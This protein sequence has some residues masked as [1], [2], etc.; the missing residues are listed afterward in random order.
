MSASH[1]A[2][3]ILAHPDSMLAEALRLARQ[4]YPVLRVKP[5]KSPATDHGF[6]DAT[7]NPAQITAWWSRNPNYM[8]GVRTGEAS[9]LAVLD[10]DIKTDPATGEVKIDGSKALQE[11]M[12]R[13]G[14]TLPDTVSVQT[15]S[16]GR[17]LYFQH[18]DGFKSN[19]HN[20]VGI[21]YRCE[22]GYIVFPPSRRADGKSYRF[23]NPPGLFEIAKA[24]EWL[25]E[26]F[27]NDE[28]PGLIEKWQPKDNG[29]VTNVAGTGKELPE[30]Y[31]H[32][33]ANDG[34]SRREDVERALEGYWNPDAYDDWYQ[35]AMALHGFPNGLEIWLA[36]ASRSGK[37]NR[38]ENIRKWEQTVPERGKTVASILSRVDRATLSDWGREHASREHEARQ[39]TER[40]SATVE[41][42]KPEGGAP[43]DFWNPW[44]EPAGPPFPLE[45]L[46]DPVADYVR[47]RYAETGA[48]ASAIAMAC[49]AVLSAAIT[50]ETRLKLNKGSWRSSAR[51]WGLLAGNVSA[52]KSLVMDGA[53]HP[54]AECQ[55][56]NAVHAR[57]LE[58]EQEAE[59]GK[60]VRVHYDRYSVNDVTPE[61]LCVAL[62]NQDRGI[63]LHADEVTAWIGSLDRY[64]NE[65]GRKFY[66][67]AYNGEPYEALRVTR[68]SPPV[69][70]LSIS[71]LGG[72]Q[73]TLLPSLQ[74]LTSDGLLQRF[75]PVVMAP[76]KPPSDD[77]DPEATVR[78][79][80]LVSA[81]VQL[82]K[83]TLHLAHGAYP[84]RDAVREL[85]D[86]VGKSDGEGEGWQGFTG[87]LTGIWGTLALIL[88]IACHG[89]QWGQA[90]PDEV[91]VETATLA[92]RIL[93]EFILPHGLEFY[94]SLN[95]GGRA[96]ARYIGTWL[97]E[98][99]GQTISAR[100]LGRGP[101]CLKRISADAV[102]KR[103]EL[104]VTGGWLVPLSDY[105]SNKKW[106]VTR[107]MT[108][109]F[110]T[111]LAR[112]RGAIAEIQERIKSGK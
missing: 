104:F 15:P 36:W 90:I 41:Q 93:E 72:I 66:L 45:C 92:R 98:R 13:N 8:I 5:D 59:T 39:R 78:W 103:M 34:T 31:D 27:R 30:P 29:A 69:N 22:G 102:A 23:D 56:A 11:V 86:T 6:Y 4:G 84:V 105:P 96:D 79:G 50:H 37:F 10:L 64:A 71:I 111:E 51:I 33:P 44:E 55:R 3:E 89:E 76:K 12:D 83:Q 48:C 68:Q 35:A 20:K 81:L 14:W 110:A 94:R 101:N 100:D 109:R 19:A 18:E 107:G 75:L 67:S 25:A 49:L 82:P 95:G 77:F 43:V 21:D 87:K 2:A 108:A 63:L 74:D 52:G 73:P 88:H 85:C 57:K 53:I 1:H 106:T 46:P 97:A 28:L 40:G 42:A 58:Q 61:A 80:M 99:E 65:T 16:G 9:G 24:P 70:N 60:R 112:T 54:L 38:A 47:A 17:H 32:P 7:T 62:A 26:F 91:S